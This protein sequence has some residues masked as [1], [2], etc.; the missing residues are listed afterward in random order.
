VQQN[1]CLKIKKPRLLF[2]M[3]QENGP[4]LFAAGNFVI[5]CLI[6]RPL[7]SIT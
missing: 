5:L 1:S 6:H 2:L 7:Y 4:R 3:I